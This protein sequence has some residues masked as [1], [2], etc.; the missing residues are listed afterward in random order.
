MLEGIRTE[1]GQ[2]LS[3]VVATVQDCYGRIRVSTTQEVL[4]VLTLKYQVSVQVGFQ[5]SK[6]FILFSKA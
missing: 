4:S 6:I 2:I 5:T 3:V 1:R